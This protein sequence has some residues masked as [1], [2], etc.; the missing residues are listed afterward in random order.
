MEITT[1]TLTAMGTVL[2]ADGVGVNG[3]TMSALNDELLFIIYVVLSNDTDLGSC[4]KSVKEL[5]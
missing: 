5:Y 3:Y 2:S 4:L 1:Q